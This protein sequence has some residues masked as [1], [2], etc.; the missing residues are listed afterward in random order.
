MDTTHGTFMV[1]DSISDGS[2]CATAS[3]TF[4]ASPCA[5]QTTRAPSDKKNETNQ[6]NVDHIEECWATK[7]PPPPLSSLREIFRLGDLYS[8]SLG[9]SR[10][11]P[12]PPPRL[13]PLSTG[14]LVYLRRYLPSI[15]RALPAGDVGDCKG[16]V[17]LSVP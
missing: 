2:N 4:S 5:T 1:N 15:H 9:G 11:F 16:R 6:P 13:S 12:P 7:P 14:I 17:P 8:L 3:S 10:L